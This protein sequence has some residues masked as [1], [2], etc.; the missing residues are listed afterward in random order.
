MILSSYISLTHLS[1]FEQPIIL[2]VL[3]GFIL[4][5]FWLSIGF[6]VMHDASHYAFFKSP[7]LN[8]YASKIW[9]AFSTWNHNLWLYHHVLFHHS[10]TNTARDADIYHFTPFFRKHTS[11]AQG[12]VLPL[13][14]PLAIPGSFLGQALHYAILGNIC[15]VMFCSTLKVP[16]NNYSLLDLS[17]M[18]LRLCLFYRMG[19]WSTV[20]YMVGCSIFYMMNVIGDHDTYD[21]SVENHYEG[22]DWLKLQI[23]NSGNFKTDC[24]IYTFV[25]GGINYQIEHHLFPSMSNSYYSQIAPI[26]K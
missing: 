17:I 15:G 13:L 7:K 3:L 23:Q 16:K 21:V 18:L 25:F 19:C 11:Q 14:Y 9:N 6:N 12:Y 22:N 5:F 26:V 10:F 24:P 2:D 8:N 4:S 20:S 1:M